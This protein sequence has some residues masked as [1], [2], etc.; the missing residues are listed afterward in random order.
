MFLFCA[1]CLLFKHKRMSSHI[2][3][4]LFSLYEYT[5]RNQWGLIYICRRVYMY[6][7]VLC[8][9]VVYFSHIKYLYVVLICLLTP[10]W[11]NDAGMLFAGC[12]L[13]S[14]DK[15]SMFY[16][17][18]YVS[19][20]IYFFFLLLFMLFWWYFCLE[21]SKELSYSDNFWFN[22]SQNIKFPIKI[23]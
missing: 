23:I 1:Q 5:N 13:W 18:G 10:I 11:M 16:I 15:Y 14:I 2:F 21:S 3:F 4:I 9:F 12:L 7:H 19:G 8:P 17:A 20:I 22:V 6:V